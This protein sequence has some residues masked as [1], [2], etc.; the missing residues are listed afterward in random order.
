[1]SKTFPFVLALICFGSFGCSIPVT[2]PEYDSLITIAGPNDQAVY[3]VSVPKYL[4]KDVQKRH[5]AVLNLAYSKVSESNLKMAEKLI[6]LEVETR[7]KKLV[8]QFKL[9]QMKD[10]RPYIRVSWLAKGG[11]CSTYANSDFID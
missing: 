6:D 11:L 2:G 3:T 4:E 8:T 10:L 5:P 1:M 7:A 9:T